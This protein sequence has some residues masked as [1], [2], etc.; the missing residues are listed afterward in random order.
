M[1]I[2]ITRTL[3]IYHF[4]RFTEPGVEVMKTLANIFDSFVGAASTTDRRANNNSPGPSNFSVCIK[5]SAS[6]TQL[7]I[8]LSY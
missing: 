7:F 5:I 8:L 6:S 4:L 3:D 1:S 2:D